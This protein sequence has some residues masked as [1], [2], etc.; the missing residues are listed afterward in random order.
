[1]HPTN[2]E[3][4]AYMFGQPSTE[5]LKRMEEHLDD[6]T[7]C[8]LTVARLVRAVMGAPEPGAGKSA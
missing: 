1:V 5:L 7:D 6:C 3:L 2:A 4:L 8:A